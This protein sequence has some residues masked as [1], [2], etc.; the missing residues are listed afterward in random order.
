[1]ANQSTKSDPIRKKY[2]RP[3]EMAES[4]S[5]WLFYFVAIIS[6]LIFVIERARYPVI[7]DLMQGAFI[8]SVLALFFIGLGIRLYWTPR[9]EDKRR[10][11]FFS[12]SFGVALTHDLTSGYYNNEQ[13][14]PF[15]RFSA[16]LLENSFFSKNIAL[17]MACGVRVQIGIYLLFW[18]TALLCR[19]TD[20][21]IAA[22]IAQAVFSEQIISKWI[23]LEWLRM[24]FESVYDGL[25]L[26][27]QSTTDFNKEEYRASVLEAFGKYETSKARGSITL[28]AKV[29]DRL[30]SK[31]SSEWE[32]IKSNLNL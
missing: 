30:N 13:T 8:I 27:V 11:D 22:A 3:L 19:T 31:L 28:S 10:Q 32:V 20:I 6:V 29:F 7:Y 1:M 12:N 15:K 2:Y 16:S 17:K 5:D 25:Y 4:F 21:A 24:R 26:L 23:R 18:L 14:D 9:A